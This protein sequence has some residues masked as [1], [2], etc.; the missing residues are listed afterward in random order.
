MSIWKDCSANNPLRAFPNPLST[1]TFP[2]SYQHHSLPVHKNRI[3]TTNFHRL[4][5]RH[6][7]PFA[8]YFLFL[9]SAMLFDPLNIWERHIYIARD[10]SADNAQVRCKA[11]G[12]NTSDI[13]WPDVGVCED[14]KVK[15][16]LQSQCA[17]N[18]VR[19]TKTCLSYQTDIWYAQLSSWLWS[20]TDVFTY[21]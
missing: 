2:F 11:N 18:F 12:A 19:F 7:T 5:R 1:V 20:S 8:V 10:T 17:P 15:L 4:R 6:E 16:R 3:Q 9:L 14:I 21:L 13:Q